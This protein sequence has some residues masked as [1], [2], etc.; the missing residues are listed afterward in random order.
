LGEDRIVLLSTHIVEDVSHICS[1]LAVIKTGYLVFK[2]TV[3]SLIAQAEGQVWVTNDE[4][5]ARENLNSVTSSRRTRAGIEYRL[6]GGISS[7]KA[8]S[9][10]PTLEDA[11]LFLMNEHP[12][13]QRGLTSA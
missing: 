7:P 6:V 4:K 8:I 12:T 13:N 10:S 9:V 11:Y 5:L 3:E 1:S 2:G